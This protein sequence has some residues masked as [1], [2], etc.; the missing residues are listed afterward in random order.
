MTD[1]RRLFAGSA[2][3]ARADQVFPVAV[4]VLVLDH[5]GTAGGL[6]LVLAGRFAAGALFGLLGGGLGQGVG[7]AQDEAPCAEGTGDPSA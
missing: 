1:V 2:A 3:S 7:R 6:R 5:G 4:A